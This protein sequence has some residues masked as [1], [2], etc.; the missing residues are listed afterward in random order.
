MR[1]QRLIYYV[2][3]CLFGGNANNGTNA[4]FGYL[5]ANNGWTTTNTNV[6]SRKCSIKI[7]GDILTLPLGKRQQNGGILLGQMI[8]NGLLKYCKG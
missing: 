7:L 5:N 2:R 3:W 6:G 1:I 8:T 4:G